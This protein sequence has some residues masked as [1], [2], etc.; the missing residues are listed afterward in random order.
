MSA[1]LAGIIDRHAIVPYSAA[2][3]P[4]FQLLVHVDTHQKLLLV[5]LLVISH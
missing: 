1:I 3:H 2:I 4:V 5:L